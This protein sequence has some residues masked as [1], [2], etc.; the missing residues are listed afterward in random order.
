MWKSMFLATGI[1]ACILGVELLLI[2]SAVILPPDGQGSGSSVTTP[3]W[4]PWSLISAGAI[5]VLHF[6]SFPRKLTL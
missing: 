2:D 3:D 4:V 5:T 6:V 1:F